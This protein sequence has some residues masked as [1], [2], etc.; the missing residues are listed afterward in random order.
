M[1]LRP[2]KKRT[3]KKRIDATPKRKEK[4]RAKRRT[5]YGATVVSAHL[6]EIAPNN[7]EVSDAWDSYQYWDGTDERTGREMNEMTFTVK[8]MVRAIVV[9]KDEKDWI[10]LFSI[11]VYPKGMGVGTRV[12]NLF[13]D[14]ADSQG[15][16][17]VLTKVK[18]WQFAKSLGWAK[19]RDHRL[20]NGYKLSESTGWTEFVYGDVPKD[21]ADY[22][23]MGYKVV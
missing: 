21:A 10:E 7:W 3:T 8:D 19:E 13:K 12:M 9:F 2:T 20:D 22:S 15:K 17:M 16:G 6:R 1:S 4:V 18:N 5:K 14:Y 11:D 23:S